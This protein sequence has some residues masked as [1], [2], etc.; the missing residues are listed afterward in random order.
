MGATL[1]AL[2]DLLNEMPKEY[3]QDVNEHSKFL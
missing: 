2:A 3:N 1:I